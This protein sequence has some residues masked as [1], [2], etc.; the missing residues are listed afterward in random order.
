MEH[1]EAHSETTVLKGAGGPILEKIHAARQLFNARG[2]ELLNDPSVGRLLGVLERQVA[3]SQKAMLD[4][5]VVEACRMCEEEEGGSCCGAGIENHY[6]V[7]L[8][9][10]NLLM[11]IQLPES[12]QQEKGCFFLGARGCI[13]KARQVL[14]V[15]YLCTAIQTLV[16]FQDL[17]FLQ[18]TNGEELDTVFLLHERI[19]RIIPR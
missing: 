7:V 17:I 6:S 5:G 8:L 10:M 1:F 4:L 3:R 19:K 11:G 2:P 18:S 9:L 14:C 13:L 12:R 16:P 15:N